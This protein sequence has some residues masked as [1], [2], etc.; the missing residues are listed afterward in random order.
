MNDLDAKLKCKLRKFV[1]DSKLGGTADCFKEGG[2]FF[3]C[4]GLGTAVRQF[5]FWVALREASSWSQ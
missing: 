1:D 5:V 2:I 3:R 4:E